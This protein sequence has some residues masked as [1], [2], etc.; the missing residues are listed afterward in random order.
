MTIW[1]LQSWYITWRFSLF[2]FFWYPL[3]DF[4]GFVFLCHRACIHFIR[5]VKS[6]VNLIDLPSYGL[7]QLTENRFIFVESDTENKLAMLFKR[8]FRNG[9]A[10]H[11]CFPCCQTQIINWNTGV[12]TKVSTFGKYFRYAQWIINDERN[13]LLPFCVID[14]F[15]QRLRHRMLESKQFTYEFLAI[16]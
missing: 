3:H 6:F 16:P 15:G 14:P 12:E 10:N 2:F 1:I 8:D 9:R 4:D 11:G 5:F 13:L 7:R